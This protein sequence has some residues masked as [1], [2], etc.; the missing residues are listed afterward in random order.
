MNTIQP[1]FS[2]GEISSSLGYR[3][4]L[5]RYFTAC[6]SLKNFIVHPHGGTSNRPGTEYIAS[7]KDSSKKSRLIGFEFSTEQAYSIEF[8]DQYCRFFMNGAPILLNGVPYEISTP[9]LEADL[10]LIK[11][12]QSADVLY[13]VHGKYAPRTLSRYGH[14][15]WV[16][17]LFDNT[18]GP[19]MRT[20]IS[21]TTITPSAAAGTI[22]LTAS[23]DLFVPSH[24]GTWWRIG[25]AND[26]G[27][28]GCVKVTAYTSPTVVTAKVMSTLTNSVTTAPAWKSGQS[29]K[30][31]TYV[32]YKSYVYRCLVHHYSG[33]GST[34]NPII[35]PTDTSYWSQYGPITITSPTTNWAEGAWSD[36]RGWPETVMF[37]QDRL[38]FGSS[39]SSPNGYWTSETG[40]YNSFIRH[41]PLEDTDGIT[42]YL[43]SRKV[44]AIRNMV[45]LGDILALTSDS[46][47]HIGPGSS[48]GAIKPTA[49][50]QNCD[51]HSGCSTA[52]PVVIKNR[53]IYVQPMG[54]IIQDMGYTYESDGYTGD[55]VSIFASHL[56]KGKTV[57]EMAY[58]QEP[59]HIIWILLNDGSAVAMTY[60]K[61]Q[62]ILACT[63]IS[64]D[65]KYESLC[66]IPG[67]GYDEVWFLINRD[68]NR[69]VERL[70]NRLTSSD[71]ADCTF[72]DSW[73]KY[74]GAPAEEISGLDHL[75]GKTVK[76]LADGYVF[77]NLTVTN[78]KITLP[79]ESSKVCIGLPYISEFE[80]LN[81]DFQTNNGTIQS[82][83]IKISSVT[84]IF[85][86][87]RGGYVG[88][89]FNHLVEVPQYSGQPTGTPIPL[90]SWN[91]TFTPTSGY[92][93]GGRVC[94][95]QVDPLP[96]TILAIIPD[97]TIGGK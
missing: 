74:E 62:Q 81:V 5:Q 54:T 29:Y 46:E 24:V 16:L 63:P 71:P 10:P 34:D 41:E 72:L 27:F 64:T 26:D 23:A 38:M 89:D 6:K 3:T 30:A 9:Y 4:D 59:D 43:T 44:N 69:C 82:Q 76:A 33:D 31:N 7:T 53:V 19:Y 55:D 45:D 92:V 91:F 93:K 21:A 15:N 67:D 65:G 22:T 50:K 90:Q 8:G 87:T 97:V 95:R 36:C 14:T 25:D 70:P 57:V 80:S 12:T 42:Q 58:Q 37:C 86:D 68:G 2:G 79:R 20:N 47:W 51:G 40:N 77:E 52:D 49:L 96:V 83:Y 84:F 60:L 73:L 94:Y 88:T 35:V 66:I 17:E 61:E 75:E 18:N 48:D 1:S 78:G 28:Y 11:Y 13:L 85:E 56:F 32:Q 39:K